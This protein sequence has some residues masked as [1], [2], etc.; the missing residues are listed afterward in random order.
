MHLQRNSEYRLDRR[1]RAC[2][3]RCGVL[4]IAG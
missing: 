2:I 4:I 3:S 1:I